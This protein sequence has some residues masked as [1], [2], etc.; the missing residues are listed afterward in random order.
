MKIVIKNK[1]LACSDT[2]QHVAN[3]ATIAQAAN[4]QFSV[5]ETSEGLEV[6]I[7]HK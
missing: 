6:S 3:L 7:G 2:A 1:T 5:K 4:L